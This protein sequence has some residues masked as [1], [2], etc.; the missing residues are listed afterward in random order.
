[1]NKLIHHFST[2]LQ[3]RD[4][5]QTEPLLNTS[6]LKWSPSQDTNYGFL[7]NKRSQRGTGH[8]GGVWEP[9]GTIAVFNH[10]CSSFTLSHLF[11]WDP[12]LQNLGVYLSKS[13]YSPL[14]GILPISDRCHSKLEICMSAWY[15]NNDL[16]PRHPGYP[17]SCRRD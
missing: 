4:E 9:I 2:T 10:F 6:C 14:Y 1:M 12:F 17:W 15:F 5:C 3:C 11:F 13:I 16:F 7:L 8:P